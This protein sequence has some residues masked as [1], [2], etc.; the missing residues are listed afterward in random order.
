[1]PERQSYESKGKYSVNIFYWF[2]TPIKKYRQMCDTRHY[3]TE[4]ERETY[5][6]QSINAYRKLAQAYNTQIIGLKVDTQYWNIN[7]L[8]NTLDKY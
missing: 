6:T 5:L 2:S 8:N 1:M 4:Q 3:N 7:R